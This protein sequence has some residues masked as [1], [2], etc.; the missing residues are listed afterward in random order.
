MCFPYVRND[1]VGVLGG[2]PD[3]ICF[4]LWLEC[5]NLN[6]CFPAYVCMMGSIVPEVG[7][8]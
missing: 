6:R 4:R 2:F 3:F 1:A 7:C 5:S 8:L